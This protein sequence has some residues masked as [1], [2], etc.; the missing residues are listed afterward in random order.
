M[1]LFPMIL[2]ASLC[3]ITGGCSRPPPPPPPDPVVFFCINT[4][5]F[6][7]TQEELDA[8]RKGGW[9]VNLAREFR[10][11]ERRDRWCVS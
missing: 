11:N 3:L 4:E 6:R 8:R 2:T 5:D 9:T 7:Y 1:R 10:S